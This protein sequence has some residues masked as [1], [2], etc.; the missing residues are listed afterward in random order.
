M[1]GKDQGKK[2]LQMKV[3]ENQAKMGYKVH[4]NDVSQPSHDKQF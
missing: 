4:L 3:E 1:E 2:D